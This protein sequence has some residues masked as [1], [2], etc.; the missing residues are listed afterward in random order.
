MPVDPRDY[1]LDELRD[2]EGTRSLEDVAAG[3]GPTSRRIELHEEPASSRRSP[4]TGPSDE[5][6]RRELRL[7]ERVYE[8]P[9]ERPYLETLPASYDA[10]T[11]VLEW[12]RTMLY[13]GGRDG[14]R[15]AL[16]F[17][18][19]VGWISARVEDTLRDH[20]AAVADEHDRGSGELGW[21]DHR[22]ALRYVAQL[23]VVHQEESGTASRQPR[24]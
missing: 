1:D 3:T 13:R 22:V 19:S 17:Y 16:A 8:G 2:T 5:S 23:A 24:R 10:E 21:N 12:V 18:R 4:S 15:S 9:L 11:T 7:L 6:V 20:V 14:T